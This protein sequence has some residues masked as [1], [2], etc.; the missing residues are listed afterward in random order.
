MEAY[1]RISSLDS[2]ISSVP[3]E[4][5]GGALRFRTGTK[6][7]VVGDSLE[8]G[9]IVEVVTTDG[10]AGWTCARDVGGS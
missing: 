5:L 10:Y 2:T 7:Q 6:V 1:C 4:K 9:S 3:V 8:P